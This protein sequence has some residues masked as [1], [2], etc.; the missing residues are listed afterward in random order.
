LRRRDEE[1]AMSTLLRFDQ[2]GSE[3]KDLVGGKGANLGFCAQAGFDVPPGF[4]ITTDAYT[5]F[6]QA[7]GLDRVIAEAMS[8]ADYA[9]SDD[10]E[11]R[12]SQ[13]RDAIK[14]TSF[15]AALSA[16]I[17]QE[18]AALGDTPLVAVRSSGSAEDLAEAS[19]A[20]LHDTYL[21]VS[22]PDAVVDAVKDCWASLWTG[23][24]TAYRHNNGFDDIAAIKM[25]VVVQLMVDSEIA[26]VMFT[27]NP[28]STDTTEIVISASWGLGEA[29]VQG[30][31]TPDEYVV[32]HADL[33]I[34]DRT[35]GTK[36]RRFVRDP[37]GYGTVLEDVPGSQ[38]AVFCLSDEQIAAVADLGRRIQA[39][40]D[41]LPQDVE[42]AFA[43]DNLY[44]L[45]ARPITG[46]D[47]SWEADADAWSTAEDD[48]DILWT[49]GF[50]E[51]WTGAKSP[52][53]YQWGAECSAK[54]Y[55]AVGNIFGIKE[56]MGPSLTNGGL[57]ANRPASMR[58]FKYYKGE[59]YYNTAVEKI[60]HTRTTLPFLRAFEASDFAWVTPAQRDEIMAT[61]FNYRDYIHGIV[62]GALVEPRSGF[63]EYQKVLQKYIDDHTEPGNEWSCVTLPDL[64]PLSDDELKQTLSRFWDEVTRYTTWITIPFFVWVPTVYSLLR[65]MIENWYTGDN[66][67]AFAELGMGAEVR[68]KTVEE[69][70]W[71]YELAEKIR[72]SQELSEL[73]QK[74]TG[75]D[76][77]AALEESDEG[78]KF[79]EDYNEFV[80]WHGH[81]G[82]EER[83]FRYPRRIEDPSIDYRNF[84]TFLSMEEVANP[85]EQEEA[86]NQRRRA[87]YADVMTNLR[88]KPI[89][90]TLRAAAFQEIYNW[91]QTFI[92]QRDDERWAY[93]H[94]Q[95]TIKVLCRELGRRLA[96][97]DI[98]ESAED[99]YFFTKDELFAMLGGPVNVRLARAKVHARKRDIEMMERRERRFPY[100]IQRGAEVVLDAESDDQSGLRGIVRN[101]GTITATARVVTRVSEIG[102]VKPGEILVCNATDPGWTPVFSVISGIVTETGGVLSH[103][104]LLSREYGLPSVQIHNAMD[105]IPDG[106]TITISPTGEVTIHDQTGESSEPPQAASP[107]P[108]LDQAAQHNTVA[109]VQ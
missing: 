54:G 95:L 40:Y 35:L 52:L 24:A 96:E 15:P 72:H 98:L 29:V 42:W 61:P 85:L 33:R 45:Q 20:G 107:H 46:V 12:T 91:I 27:G 53:Y 62:H 38:R 84:Q 5:E 58:V 64:P 71:S 8:T 14:A 13:I 23:R 70:H 77:F 90:G 105:L 80:R 6:L 44:L 17:S 74:H 10:L 7:T 104:S 2:P 108:Q 86:V 89:I 76:F 87:A 79:L 109:A 92:C 94:W 57:D 69:N 22:G 102:R 36:E 21:Y 16:Q 34:K 28:M 68:T 55:H 81:R 3:T 11:A 100:Y 82:H 88:R 25:A 97:R 73:F 67:D 99:F 60:I 59:C 106:A 93:E 50:A 48:D 49:R 31:I 32:K 26:G 101:A 37:I 4:I 30:I 18:Y 1:K 66:A 65:Y 83:D 78:R 19:F 41:E 39:H 103:A 63:W 47:F 43:N 51:L 56:L 9:D 75:T